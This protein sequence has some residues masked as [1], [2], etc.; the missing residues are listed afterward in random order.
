MGSQ[1]L[2]PRHRPTNMTF[3]IGPFAADNVPQN[4]PAVEVPPGASV[5]VRAHNGTDTG[6]AHVAYVA[7]SSDDV[8]TPLHRTN[9]A[10]NTQIAFPVANVRNVWAMGKTGD[11]VQIQVVGA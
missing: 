2:G 11:G 6:N 3:L 4:G 5:Y 10:P 7:T 1:V 8:N 9:L